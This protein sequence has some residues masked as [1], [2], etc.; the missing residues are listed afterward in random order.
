MSAPGNK[1]SVQLRIVRALQATPCMDDAGIAAATGIPQ[2]SVRR[3][4][5]HLQAAGTLVAD[6]AGYRVRKPYEN[7]DRYT[8]KQE[9][10]WR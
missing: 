10:P 3:T 9:L 2:P 6:G 4:R 7:V 8:G 5:L 1:P